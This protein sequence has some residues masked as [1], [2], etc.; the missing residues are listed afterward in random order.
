MTKRSSFNIFTATSNNLSHCRNNC[1][2]CPALSYKNFKI[3]QKKEHKRMQ[4]SFYKVK[5]EL[6][7]LFSIYIYISFYIYLYIVFFYV[8]CKRTLHAFFAFFYILCKRMLHSLK[9]RKRTERS[10]QKRMRCPTL[11]TIN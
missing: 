3:S 5:K 2:K 10:E 7:V 8:L 9:E 11:F 1:H 4:R 6:N